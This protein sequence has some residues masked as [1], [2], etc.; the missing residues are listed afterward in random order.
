MKE[1]EKMLVITILTNYITTKEK[2]L[3]TR[4]QYRMVKEIIKKLMGD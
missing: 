4:E 3:L 2:I 1:E